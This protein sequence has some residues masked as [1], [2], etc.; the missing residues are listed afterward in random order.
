MYTGVRQLGNLSRDIWMRGSV[1]STEE[2]YLWYA[3]VRTKK[4]SKVE[5]FQCVFEKLRW[6]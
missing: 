3:L 5:G 6:Y 2:F 1:S 4:T